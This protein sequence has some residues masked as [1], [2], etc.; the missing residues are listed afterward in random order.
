VGVPFVEVV[1]QSW[2]THADNFPITRRNSEALDPAMSA[3]IEDLRDRGLLESTLIICMGEFGRT[4]RFENSASGRGPGRGH[5]GRAWS[6]VLFGGGIPGGQVIGRTD[7]IGGTV[8]EQPVSAG[9]F[10]ATICQ[11]LGINWEKLNDGPGGRTVRIT[12]EGSQPI[13]QLVQAPSSA[14]A[15]TAG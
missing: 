9:D 14:T 1:M 5:Y 10:F 8:E 3:L 12:R 7:K 11:I 2:D 15:R 4:P 6:T 13:K